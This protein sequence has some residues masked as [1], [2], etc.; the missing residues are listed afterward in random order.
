M[1][2]K[3]FEGRRSPSLVVDACDEVVAMLEHCEHMLEVACS[4]LLAGEEVDVAGVR[5]ED[6]QVHEAEGCARRHIATHLAVDP[7]LDLPASL[8]LV[9]IT[10]YAERIGDYAKSLL[11]LNEWSG[12]ISGDCRPMA[13]C[14]DNHRMIQP[15]FRQTIAALRQCEPELASDVMRAHALVK[16]KSDAVLA[17]TMADPG[18]DRPAFLFT[19][20]SR[21]LRRVSANLSNIAS[22]LANPLDRVGHN[23]EAGRQQDQARHGA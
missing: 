23:D 10:Y 13:M 18:A 22:S 21:F 15:M 9:S 3:L 2:K 16:E 5:A 6:R 1:L 7:D 20:A 17:A 14:W 19:L 11:E 12:L 8:D 4:A